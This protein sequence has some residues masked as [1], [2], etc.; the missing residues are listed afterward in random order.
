MPRGFSLERRVQF[1]E[2]DMAGVL[3][4]ANYYRLMEE[5]E[6][7]FWRSLGTSV[8]VHDADGELSW[9]RVATSCEYF[10]PARFEEVLEL[11]FQVTEV[12]DRSFTYEVE[13]RREAKMIA[14]GTTKA[15]C[16]RSGGGKFRA[17]TIPE[18][19]REI[20]LAARAAPA[21]A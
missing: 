10:T 15:V 19:L 12:G 13:F 9:P 6:H 16:C 3:H 11:A 2:T 1:A 4:F 18:A 5:V 17:I 21:H 7:A 8:I 20:L 14:R